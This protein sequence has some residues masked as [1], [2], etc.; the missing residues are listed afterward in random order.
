MSVFLVGLKNIYIYVI[1]NRK[2][3]CFPT[4]PTTLTLFHYA[5]DEAQESLLLLVGGVDFAKAKDEMV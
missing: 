2:G 5:W 1:F 4:T 3:Y